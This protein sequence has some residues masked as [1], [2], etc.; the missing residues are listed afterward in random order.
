MMNTMEAKA[1]ELGRIIGQSAEYQAV[2]R[3]NDAAGNDRDT[4]MLLRQL[5]QL[6][7]EAQQ[8]IQRGE[9][10]TPEMEQ[11]LDDLLQ[12]VQTNPVYQ[13]ALVTQENFDKLMMRVNEWIL[14]GIRKGSVSPI[15][16]LG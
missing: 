15:I 9:H 13:S 14:D 10:P 2:K 7:S 12:K 16:T 11:K 4:G 6:R 5:E 3:A 8:M 1:N